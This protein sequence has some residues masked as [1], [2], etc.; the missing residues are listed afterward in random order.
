M[1]IQPGKDI[2]E[3]VHTVDQALVF[4]S[5]KGKAIV[6]GKEQEVKAG[7]MVVVPAGTIHQFW[8]TGLTPL[9]RNVPSEAL[10][11]PKKS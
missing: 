4:T 2:G 9:V 3:E 10:I 11:E 5:G 6:A 7:D 1:T 8:N